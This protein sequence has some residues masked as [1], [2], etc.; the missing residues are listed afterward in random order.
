MATESGEPSAARSKDDIQ[1]LLEQHLPDLQQLY[2]DTYKWINWEDAYTVRRL[3]LEAGLL[4][5]NE[6][7]HVGLHV[8]NDYLVMRLSEFQSD[9]NYL[10]RCSRQLLLDKAVHHHVLTDAEAAKQSSTDVTVLKCYLWTLVDDTVVRAA[11]RRYAIVC[12]HIMVRGSIIA[13]LVAMTAAREDR[14]NELPILLRG[15]HPRVE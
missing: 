8:S 12:S 10:R 7:R 2:G 5:D 13:N 4:R 3:A 6:A 14:W 15:R 11:L 1:A 9:V